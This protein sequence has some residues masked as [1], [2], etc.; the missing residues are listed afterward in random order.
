MEYLAQ[1]LHGVL[2]LL[3]PVEVVSLA[4]IPRQVI[5]LP[6]VPGVAPVWPLGVKVG[7]QEAHPLREAE[8]GRPHR[9]A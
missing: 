5:Q 1:H 6:P 3:Q 9:V 7:V 8:L 4:G 2:P